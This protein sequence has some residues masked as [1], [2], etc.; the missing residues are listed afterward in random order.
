MSQYDLGQFPALRHFKIRLKTSFDG[1][2]RMLSLLRQLLSTTSGIETLEIDIHWGNDGHGNLFL[3]DAGWS[4]LNE[5]LTGGNFTSLRNVIIRLRINGCCGDDRDKL[6]Y[7][8]FVLSYVNI[9]FSLISR[10]C[11]LETYVEIC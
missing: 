1:N 2:I 6:E 3:F 11:T 9:L 8:N 10:Q 5:A 4:S 7:K